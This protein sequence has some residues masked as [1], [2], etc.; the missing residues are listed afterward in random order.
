MMLG[1]LAHHLLG[2]TRQ[3]RLE[4]WTDDTLLGTSLV[5]EEL[6]AALLA[7]AG[8]LFGIEGGIASKKGLLKDLGSDGT[9]NDTIILIKLIIT[10]RVS[11][12]TTFE[13]FA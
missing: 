9:A 6:I 12:D 8:L 11:G 13:M 5:E 2:N 4:D 3:I 7:R 10:K 1:V